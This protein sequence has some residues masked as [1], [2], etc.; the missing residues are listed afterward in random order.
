M[1]PLYGGQGKG[2]YK[3]A[4]T[5]ENDA[6]EE[7]AKLKDYIVEEIIC[8]HPALSD[9]NKS[10]VNTVRVVTFYWKGKA[11]IISTT[12][13]T[14]MKGS[15]VDNLHSCD[16]QCWQIDPCDGVIFTQSYGYNYHSCKVHL[17]SGC[18]VLGL[19]VPN[20]DM[21]KDCVINAQKEFKR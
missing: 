3:Y 16:S 14:R 10:S 13:R 6:K 12:L 7:F 8:Q 20:W 15:C 1:Q 17:G 2:I 19:R 21:I 11:Y 18:Q 5:T 4:Y 9:I